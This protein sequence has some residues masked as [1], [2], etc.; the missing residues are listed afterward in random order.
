M[1]LQD[2]EPEA[3]IIPIKASIKYYDSYMENNSSTETKT[4][5][6]E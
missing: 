2:N 1:D 4:S 6:N 3:Q 5:L